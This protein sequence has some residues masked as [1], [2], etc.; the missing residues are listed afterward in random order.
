MKNLK[1]EEKFR[2][3]LRTFQIELSDYQMSQLN[4]YYE[5]LIEWNE[6]INLTTITEYEE[7]LTKHFLDSLSISGVLKNKE[8]I[9][10]IDVGTGAGFPGIPI[11]IVYPKISLTLLDSLKKRIL[12][13]DEVIAELNLTEI[14][15]I[16]G[17]AEDCARMKE[18]REQY[19]IC[20]SRAVANLAALSELCLPFVK[21]KGVFI[22]YKSEKADMEIEQAK[23]AISLFGGDIIEK[24][25]FRLPNTDY[26]RNLVRIQKTKQTP[27]KYPRK[28][29]TPTKQPIL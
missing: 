10:M 7:V 18:H 21:E 12:F 22:S 4:R 2:D 29:G 19:D 14:E 13:L 15:T 26:E 6:K 20:V 5:L 1:A 27:M 28:A 9:K 11:K 16:H 8:N 24:E 25:S 3:E 17:R 23:N